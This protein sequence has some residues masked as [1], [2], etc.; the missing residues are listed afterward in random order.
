MDN[1]DPL[2]PAEKRSQH[3]EELLSSLLTSLHHV[4]W[5]TSGDGSQLLY[6]NPAAEDLYGRPLREFYENPN[7]WSDAIHPDDRANVQRMLRGLRNRQEV[8]QEYRI[9]RPSGEIRW[10]EDRVTVVNGTDDEPARIGGIAT[11]ITDRKLAEEALHAS[12]AVYH[13]LVESLPLNVLRK[14][15]DGRIVFGNQKYCEAMQSTFE[16]LEGKTDFDLFPAELA[17]KYVRDD[18]HVLETG[19]LLNEIEEYSTRD[20]EKLYVE[21]FKGPVRDADGSI[22]GT[23]VMFWDVTARHEAEEALDYERELLHALLDNVPDSIYFK[24]RESRFVRVSSSL[25]RKFGLTDQ[26]EVI[27]KSDADFFSEEHARQAKN[28]EQR[29]ISTGLPL[30]GTTERE[31]WFDAPDTWCIT[32][33]LPLRDKDGKTIGTFGISTDVTDRKRAEDA[34][35]RERDMLRTLMDH[36]PD[37]IFVK[38]TE[39]RFVTANT[40]IVRVLG[41]KSLQDVIGKT[42]ADFAPADLADH[43]AQDDQR[44][45]RSGE[46]LID[47]EESVVGPDGKKVCLLTTKVPLHDAG[48][49]VTGLVGI[50]RNITKRKLA[51]EALRKTKEAADSANRAKSDFLANMSHEIRTPMNAIIGMTE[52]L[53]DTNLDASQREYIR[54]VHESGES[55]L[56]LIN[57]ILDFSKVEAGKLELDCLAFNLP[58]T[59]GDAMKSLAIRAHRKHLELAFHISPDL[60]NVLV[61]DPARLRQIVVNLVGNAIKFTESGEVFLDVQYES[62]TSTELVLRFAVSDTGIGIPQHKLRSVFGVFEQADS[63]T[64]RNFGGTGLGL[65]ICKSLVEMM[66]GRIWVESTLGT[67]STF[68]FTATFEQTDEPMPEVTRPDIER[69]RGMRVL[70]VDDN[71]T[72]RRVLEEMLRVRG[73][74]PVAVSCAKDAIEVLRESRGSGNGFPL[75]LTDIN[76]PEVDGFTLSEWI[77]QDESLRGA[78]IMA[79][80]SGDRTGDRQRCEKLGIAAHLMKP[81]K[82]SE[83]FDAIVMAFHATTTDRTKPFPSGIEVKSEIPSLRILLAEDA[84]PNQL[85][86]VGLLK[87]WEHTVVVAN[88]GQEAIER[89]KSEPFDLVLMDVQ[90]PRVDGLQATQVIRKLEREDK[91]PLQSRSPIP[92]IAMTAHAMKGDEERC[93]S[94]GMDGYVSKPVRV[95]HLYDQIAAFF[96]PAEECASESAKRT[97]AS[98]AGRPGAGESD[99][100]WNQTAALESVRWDADL[101]VVVAKAF[102]REH[103]EQ[104]QRLQAAIEEG[105]APTV[106]RMAHLIRGVMSTFGAEKA[107]T[108]A[109]QLET[110][111]RTEELQG[112]D[113]L[114][115]SLRETLAVVA[116][117]LTEYIDHPDA[118]V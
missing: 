40:A 3:T 59:L 56:S 75:V 11:D 71:A 101:L 21:V 110:M 14:D 96:A 5:C 55:L 52:L 98:E 46:P 35:A 33:K 115:E 78:V 116:A 117:A 105:D 23:Q 27:G 25:V 47:S 30:L 114:F 9:V 92:I 58:E 69:I 93:L 26:Q 107:I 34:L 41:A 28:D 60:P 84:V 57:D 10:L 106:K 118:Q 70:V 61:G 111:G 86:A 74:E 1:A 80:T 99:A 22:V 16:E 109:E 68:F 64:T 20:G 113:A 4:M 42:D 76:M 104:Q 18:Q 100:P 103:L 95:S 8:Q 29:V 66:R 79:L 102:L 88:D 94:S 45:I 12:E 7:V 6:I 37:L 83:L 13:S 112:A 49:K 24:D 44:V 67:G 36:L 73:M 65:A 38:D 85:L 51:E 53:L 31:T 54:M 90:M 19:E 77:K 97:P 50:G 89:L 108:L 32:T 91:L 39:G 82:Q 87:K 17:K 2:G 15:C 48:G 43:Y 63:S 81:V 62:Q 72:N